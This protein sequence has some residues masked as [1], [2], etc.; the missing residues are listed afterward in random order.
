M[1]SCWEG[2][3]GCEREA[4]GK[5]S[6]GQI[7]R[8]EDD[9]ETRRERGSGERR[10]GQERNTAWDRENGL[11]EGERKREHPSKQERRGVWGLSWARF[12]LG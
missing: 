7:D 8:K 10:E 12:C 6:L 11:W 1:G 9:G 3:P 5:K 2:D 4:R